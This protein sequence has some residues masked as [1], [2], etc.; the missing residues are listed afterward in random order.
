MKYPP[1]PRAAVRA[2]FL[3]PR[4]TSDPPKAPARGE[5]ELRGVTRSPAPRGHNNPP[6]PGLPHNAPRITEFSSSREEVAASAV[7]HGGKGAA[8][9]GCTPKKARK[10]PHARTYAA[11]SGGHKQRARGQCRGTCA[12]SEIRPHEMWNSCAGP[13][14]RRASVAWHNDNTLE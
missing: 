13:R 12:R 5:D 1:I 3:K 9:E 2:I 6:L 11:R 10:F 4:L 14:L 8:R 7:P